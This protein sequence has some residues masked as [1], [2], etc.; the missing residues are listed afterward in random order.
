MGLDCQTDWLTVCMIN[1][2]SVIERTERSLPVSLDFRTSSVTYTGS[3]TDGKRVDPLRQTGLRHAFGRSGWDVRVLS[4]SETEFH[5]C[6]TALPL[7]ILS[8]TK[9]QTSSLDF[10]IFMLLPRLVPALYGPRT[11][12]L[13]TLRVAVHAAK[14]LCPRTRPWMSVMAC[15]ERQKAET[16]HASSTLKLRLHCRLRPAAIGWPKLYDAGL[17][18]HLAHGKLAR[19]WIS[20]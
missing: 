14:E 17:P 11:P 18:R 13:L 1:Q 8:V 15:C 10:I 20:S 6:L 5:R 9:T 12:K 19:C 4:L 3:D 16:R 7:S 2:E